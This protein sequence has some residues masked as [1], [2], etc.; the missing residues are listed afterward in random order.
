[1]SVL[2]PHFGHILPLLVF[3]TAYGLLFAFVLLS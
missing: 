3:A 2:I 1:M